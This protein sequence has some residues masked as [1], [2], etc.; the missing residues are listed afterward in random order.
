MKNFAKA[1]LIALTATSMTV[2]A[3]AAS[4]SVAGSTRTGTGT[5]NA[6]SPKGNHNCTIN[7]ID[8]TLNSSSLITLTDTA[9]TGTNCSDAEGSFQN[10]EVQPVTTSSVNLVEVDFQAP[11]GLCQ[12]FNVG[13]AYNNTTGTASGSG[14]GI[15][16]LCY[17]NS[18]S[19][20]LDSKVTII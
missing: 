7:T 14:I 3:Y 9:M 12:E 19:V 5:L 16:W 20:T 18:V 13:L 8:W 10:I 6:D 11:F 2:P 1:A 4:F 15:G 17:V